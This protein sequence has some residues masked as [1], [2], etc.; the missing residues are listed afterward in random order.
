M[1]EVIAA[2]ETTL[3][4]ANTRPA[5]SAKKW[6]GCF[7]GG[8]VLIAMLAASAV[9]IILWNSNASQISVAKAEQTRSA[10]QVKNLYLTMTASVPSKAPST[11]IIIPSPTTRPSSVP[12]NAPTLQASVKSSRIQSREG[13][14]LRFK[15]MG[16]Y[17]R[18]A[19]CTLISQF[20][21]WY[22]VK[23]PDG[24]GWVYKDWLEIPPNIDVSKVPEI[25]YNDLPFNI[26]KYFPK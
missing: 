13:P 12:T 5:S 4:R 21:G 19:T 14:D 22:Y 2:I 16:N 17:Q 3:S 1:N 23:F 8:L 20:R 9:G 10:L 7:A 11:T 26:R 15:S 18:G 6:I 24:E 25:S